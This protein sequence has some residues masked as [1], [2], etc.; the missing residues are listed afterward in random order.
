LL[1]QANIVGVPGSSFGPAGEGYVRFSLSVPTERI[2]AAAA[3]M[4]G[5]KW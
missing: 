5:L 4:K 2:R 3:R 1:E